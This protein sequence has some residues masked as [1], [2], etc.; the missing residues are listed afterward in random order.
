MHKI[1][2]V[3]TAAL[4][5]DLVVKRF[6]KLPH[7]ISNTSYKVEASGIGLPMSFTLELRKP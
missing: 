3:I 1:S 4:E 7:H 6:E 2:D 5:A